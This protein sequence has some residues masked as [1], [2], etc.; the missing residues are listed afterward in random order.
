MSVTTSTYFFII[1]KQPNT[2]NFINL[3][4]PITEESASKFILD[5]NLFDR[6]SR[7]NKIVYIDSP[8]GSVLAGVKI[9]DQIEKYQM[10]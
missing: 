9:I 7:P 8:G 2:T 5:L 4:G 1:L 10:Y 6:K 3:Q